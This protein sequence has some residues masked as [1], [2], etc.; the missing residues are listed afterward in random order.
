[1]QGKL[2]TSLFFLHTLSRVIVGVPAAISHGHSG[3]ACGLQ[4]AAP[5]TEQEANGELQ[6]GLQ[7]GS[8][9]LLPH[10]HQRAESHYP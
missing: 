1:M 4:S 10:D 6:W 8:F 2:R 5:L 9:N 3:W 7:M